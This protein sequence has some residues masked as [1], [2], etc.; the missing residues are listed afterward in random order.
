[1]GCLGQTARQIGSRTE[2]LPRF[3]S[4]DH[5]NPNLIILRCRFRSLHEAP[6]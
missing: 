5:Q 4:T 1:M 6:A 3:T 2:S